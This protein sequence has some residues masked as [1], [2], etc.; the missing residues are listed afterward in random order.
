MHLRD[1]SLLNPFSEGVFLKVA[2]FDSDFGVL[3]CPD[4]MVLD[5]PYMVVRLLFLNIIS[6]V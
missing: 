6:N 1:T 2:V 5:L 4:S 3:L